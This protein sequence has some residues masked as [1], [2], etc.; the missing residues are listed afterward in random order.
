M[1]VLIGDKV[2]EEYE[3]EKKGDIPARKPCIY[4]GIEVD[5]DQEDILLLPPSHQTF[6]RIKMSE[7]EM[8]LE[9]CTMKANWE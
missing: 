3:K 4:G 9:K 1:G 6:P 7:I 8:E 5:K 2:L